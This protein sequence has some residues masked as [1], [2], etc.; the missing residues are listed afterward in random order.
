MIP[1]ERIEELIEEYSGYDPCIKLGAVFGTC[2]MGEFIQLLQIAHPM[3]AAVACLS[4][5]AT[6][7][8]CKPDDTLK[9]CIICGFVV[10]M[11]YEAEKP[12]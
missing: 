4:A 2:L 10:D 6:N 8:P 5:M 7:E 12:V 11:K 1:V 9:R 3:N